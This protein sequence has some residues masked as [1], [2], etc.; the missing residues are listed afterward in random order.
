MNGKRD[1]VA[2]VSVG[3]AACVACCAGPILG[4]LAALGIGTVAAGLLF[5]T[6]GLVVAAV[7]I[8]VILQR[9][10]GRSATKCADDVVPVEAET[11]TIRASR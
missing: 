8:V 7:V 4:V 2:I 11:P 6:I 9:Q 1:N 5:G 3:A 10:Q